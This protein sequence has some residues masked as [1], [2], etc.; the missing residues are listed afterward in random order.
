MGFVTGF[1]LV[2]FSILLLAELLILLTTSF[3]LPRKT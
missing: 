2:S 3:K 1:G